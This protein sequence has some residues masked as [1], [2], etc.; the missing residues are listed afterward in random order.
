VRS[1]IDHPLMA[2]EMEEIHE[3]GRRMGVR[4]LQP[5][6]DADLVEF[7]YRIP[8]DL[9]NRGGRTKG[10]VRDML[11]RRFPEAGF[12]RHR[13]IT[14]TGFF[15]SVLTREA[16]TAWE[17]MEGT[18]TLARMGLVEPRALENAIRAHASGH[19]PA[20]VHRVWD[21]LNVESWTRPRF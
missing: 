1:S 19:D 11:A 18:P 13:K 5:F 15:R 3:T 20:R 6:W 12:E 8:P 10:L 14:A 9:L 7:L 17:V 16:G 21:V 2:L 4:I